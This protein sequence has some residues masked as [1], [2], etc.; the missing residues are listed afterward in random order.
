MDLI[1]CNGPVYEQILKKGD[2]RQTLFT[3]S[4]KVGEHLVKVL[5]GKV[6][7]EGSNM[8]ASKQ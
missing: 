7:L 5:N 6:K 2:A 8:A 3:G 4:S 1:H